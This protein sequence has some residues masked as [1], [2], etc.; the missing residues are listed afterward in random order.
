MLHT[1]SY[2][3]HVRHRTR[4]MSY[5]V[6]VQHRISMSYVRHV[7]H[8]N[9]RCRTCIRYR[10]SDVRHRMLSSYTT[11]YV[12]TYISYF[13]AYNIAYNIAYDIVYDIVCYVHSI[14]FGAGSRFRGFILH[15]RLR[16][17]RSLQLCMA[18]YF[19][20]HRLPHQRRQGQAAPGRHRRC[21]CQWLQGTLKEVT[22]DLILVDS[23][24]D[25]LPIQCD[26]IRFLL[27]RQ[28]LD[29]ALASAPP[30]VEQELTRFNRDLF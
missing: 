13:L 27:W 8:R 15:A 28:A 12:L 25:W 10:R 9:I 2:V 6:H 29:A 17:H 22:A 7:R 16:R 21:S 1:M 11:S 4:T 14:G 23:F 20:R 3:M 19:F 26:K 18:V 30:P 5:V 24:L